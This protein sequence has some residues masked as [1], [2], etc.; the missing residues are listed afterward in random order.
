[1]I[2]VIRDPQSGRNVV[3]SGGITLYHEYQSGDRLSDEEWR[4]AM[5]KPGGPQPVPWIAR[6]LAPP[7]PK[8]VKD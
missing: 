1:M 2:I 3:C 7:E 6:Y 4:A 8:K 5:L